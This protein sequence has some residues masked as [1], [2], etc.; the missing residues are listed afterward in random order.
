MSDS[1]FSGYFRF[2]GRNGTIMDG[3]GG[4]VEMSGMSVRHSPK[5]SN[6]DNKNKNQT[7]MENTGESCTLS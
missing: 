3:G 2:L 5:A 6:S 7:V 4:H 1:F